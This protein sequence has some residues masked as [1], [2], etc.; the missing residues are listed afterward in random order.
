MLT[1]PMLARLV[2][3]AELTSSGGIFSHFAIWKKNLCKWRIAK[4]SSRESMNPKAMVFSYSIDLPHFAA[5]FS[6]YYDLL[7]LLMLIK[8]FHYSYYC[9]CCYY[10]SHFYFHHH[11]YYHPY[12][13]VYSNWNNKCYYYYSFLTC[14]DYCDYHTNIAHLPNKHFPRDFLQKQRLQ[15][16]KTNISSKT[17]GKSNTPDL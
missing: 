9:Y 6:H 5:P 8:L 13:Y 17:S 2:L 1:R 12:P 11:Y 15:T 16:S 4:D 14:Y 7:V 3:V 10:H